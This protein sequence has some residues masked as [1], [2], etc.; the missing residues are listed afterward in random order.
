MCIPFLAEM[1]LYAGPLVFSQGMTYLPLKALSR[2]VAARRAQH[3]VQDFTCLD[4]LLVL[5]FA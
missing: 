2:M 4:Q 3:K 1:A 5:A